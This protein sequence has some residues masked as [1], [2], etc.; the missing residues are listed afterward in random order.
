MDLFGLPAD[1]DTIHP[2]CEK[3]GLLLLEDGAQGFGDIGTT[4]FPR[5]NR[6]DDMAMAA[7]FSR[8][9]TSGRP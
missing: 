7:R 3:Y 8:I 4:L 1:Y 9:T 5:R 2:I 6:W